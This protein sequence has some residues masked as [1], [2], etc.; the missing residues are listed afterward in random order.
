MAAFPRFVDSFWSKVPVW[1]QTPNGVKYLTP[2]IAFFDVAH[3]VFRQGMHASLP[4]LGTPTALDVIG[5][6]RAMIRGDG[7]SADSYAARLPEWRDRARTWGSQYAIARALHEYVSGNPK[8]RI[9]NR[10][11][12][13]V[14]CDVDGSMTV[15]D[16]TWDW[17]SLSNP[18]RNDP[19]APWWAELWIVIYAPPWAKTG[20]AINSPGSAPNAGPYGIGQ[21]VPRLPVDVVKREI[22]QYKSDHSFVRCVIWAYDSTL[23][24][25]ST[26]ATMP[27]GTWGQWSYPTGQSST[28][29]HRLRS[30]RSL[31]CRYWEPERHPHPY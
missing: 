16:V 22:E 9:V 19:D 30:N 13:M 2:L 12:V 20:P 24:D 29:V 27:D 8:V 15:E 18:E 21:V 6:M 23:F 3:D 4:G 28:N 26:P 17:D 14:T 10:N 31:T 5:R 11:G 1:L 25:P 7:E